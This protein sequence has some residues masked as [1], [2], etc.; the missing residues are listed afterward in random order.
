MDAEKYKMQY[1]EIVE[2]YQKDKEALH[3]ELDNLML[4]I[5]EENINKELS[6]CIENI[7]NICWYA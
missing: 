6:Q 7:L 1:L 4:K 3:V 2:K 5:I